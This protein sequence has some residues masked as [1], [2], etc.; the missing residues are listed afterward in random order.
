[1]IKNM[2]IKFKWVSLLLLVLVSVNKLW[3]QDVHFSQSES[4]PLYINPALAGNFEGQGRLIFNHKNQWNSFTQA[5]STNAVSFDFEQQ[6][7][8]P[9]MSIASGIQLLSDIAGVGNFGTK[10]FM[11]PLTIHYQFP[12]PE[13]R[14]SLGIY[15][16][17][18]QYGLEVIR[19]SFGDQFNGHYYNPSISTGEAYSGNAPGFADFGTG[20]Q[21]TF[22]LHNWELSSGLAYYHVNQP[23]ISFSG[24]AYS[25]I[26][27]KATINIS[28]EK[29]LKSS[30]RIKPSLVFFKQAENTELL[31]G[32]FLTFT[33]NSSFFHTMEA[34]LFYRNRDALIAQYVIYYL[35]YRLGF[36]YDINISGL[37]EV[38]HG[39]GGFEFSLVYILQ[40]AKKAPQ[41][42]PSYCPELI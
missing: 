9:Q 39:Q 8:N 25:V 34:G 13:L 41:Y 4:I 18:T 40:K 24:Q 29:E 28:A 20:I 33:P 10:L 11:I 1:M 26:P 6:V 12:S 27:K 17:I 38:S 3:C 35:N 31:L 37:S 22:P 5:Y 32:S 30:L 36:S 19:L 21:F 7:I 2:N 42:S 14:I 23:S 16:G 15:G